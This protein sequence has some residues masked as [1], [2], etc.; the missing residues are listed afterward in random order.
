MAEGTDYPESIINYRESLKK[1]SQAE[2][3]ILSEIVSM[4]GVKEREDNKI[5]AKLS[6]HEF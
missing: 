3:E 2:S 1:I 4:L 5:E 6:S